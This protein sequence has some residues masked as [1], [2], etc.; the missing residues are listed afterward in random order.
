MSQN[1]AYQVTLRGLPAEFL[2]EIKQEA[3]R[4]G[5]SISQTLSNRLFPGKK[6]EGACASLTKYAGTWNKKRTD[7]FNKT[8]AEGR[9]VDTKEWSQ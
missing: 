3:R 8:L 5:I 6:N 9:K 4:L 2:K 7:Q 1:R